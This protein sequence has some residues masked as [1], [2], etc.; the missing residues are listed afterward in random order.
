MKRYNTVHYYK[1]FKKEYLEFILFVKCKDFFY[2]YDSDARIVNFL[3]HKE[4]NGEYKIKKINF[5][6]LLKILHR[7]DLNVVLVG[8]KNAREYY[9]ERESCYRKIKKMSKQYFKSKL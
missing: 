2:T 1:E 9:T 8:S 3:L 5:Q 7:N 6:K 4:D